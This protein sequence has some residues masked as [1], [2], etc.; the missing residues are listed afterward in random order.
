MSGGGMGATKITRRSLLKGAG[1]G[2]GATV[3]GAVGVPVGAAEGDAVFGVIEQIFAAS[4][5]VLLRTADGV[6]VVQLEDDASFWKDEQTTLDAF[7]VG[8]EVS[9]DGDP[10]GDVVVGRTMK[11][12]LRIVEGEIEH[13][14]EMSCG[15]PVA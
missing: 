2:I 14:R 13:G 3:V 6:S 5:T 11:S 10:I 4:R 12:V 9:I 15:W 1:L 8:D 7:V